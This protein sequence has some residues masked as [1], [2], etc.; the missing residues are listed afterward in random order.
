MTVASACTADSAKPFAANAAPGNGA[1]VASSV[2]PPIVSTGEDPSCQCRIVMKQVAALGD[3]DDADAFKT[4]TILARDGMGRYFAA[5]TSSAS[6]V[7]MFS[8]GGKPL[9]TLGRRGE[10]P[11]ELGRLRH[12]RAYRGDSVLVM[13]RT[14]LV[15]SAPSGKAVRWHSLPTGVQ[16]YRF[17]ALETGQV[18]VNN[19]V[20]THPTF[21]LLDRTF[22]PVREFGRPIADSSRN[23]EDA[24][25]YL[26]VGL[27]SGRF[28]A[29]KQHYNYGIEIWDTTGTLVRHFDKAPA[30]YHA[31]TEADK[32]AKGNLVFDFPVVGGV[33]A[34]GQQLWI[35]TRVP[36]PHWKDPRPVQPRAARGREVAFKPLPLSEM[37]QR[38][39]TVIEVV[40]ITTGRVLVSQ[41]FD[42][43]VSHVMEGGLLYNFREAPSLLVRADVW[44]ADIV[45][46]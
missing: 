34:N 38:Y 17:A 43:L 35:V 5:V 11:G 6:S 42:V 23:D 12:V 3:D 8:A 7:G 46:R 36:D 37:D 26:I 16:G 19:Y 21:A 44:R 41:R 18:V 39:D 45:R 10:G 2:V 25:Q 40:D 29:V 30:W 28:A 4:G 9:A 33:F 20:G 15:L 32:I 13:D 22:T 27:D 31:W 24:F 1:T 14:N